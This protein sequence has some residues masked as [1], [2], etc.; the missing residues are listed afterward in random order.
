MRVLHVESRTI[1]PNENDQFIRIPLGA[2]DGDFG[3]WPLARELDR[4]GN[5]VDENESKH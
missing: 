3:L 2:S 5:E 1:I 4:I